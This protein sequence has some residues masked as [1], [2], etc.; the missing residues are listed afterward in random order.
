M[1]CENC[2]LKNL[3]LQDCFSRRYTVDELKF[4]SRILKII[5]DNK[6]Q[7]AISEV[8]GFLELLDFRIN[9]YDKLGCCE[10]QQLRKIVDD[11]RQTGEL[12]Q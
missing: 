6:K 11:F 2:E 8:D 4:I 5:E 9:E 12:S 1:S 7:K 10:S 3:C